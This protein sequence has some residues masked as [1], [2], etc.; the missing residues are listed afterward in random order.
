MN[1]NDFGDFYATVSQVAPALLLAIVVDAGLEKNLAG[2]GNIRTRFDLVF[3]RL[4]WI[5]VVLTAFSAM[6]ISLWQLSYGYNDPRM[7]TTVLCALAFTSFALSLLLLRRVLHN[8]PYHWT[9]SRPGEWDWEP[10]HNRWKWSGQGSL[11]DGTT[12]AP[13]SGEVTLNWTSTT[14]PPGK[15]GR[16]KYKRLGH[17]SGTWTWYG[18]SEWKTPDGQSSG[19]YVVNW[20]HP[21]PPPL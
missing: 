20:K 1:G 4:A 14:M 11:F 7:R 9:A 10:L 13:H 17:D 16:W 15:S 3:A 6:G 5:L 18:A 12:G 19:A 21:S 2:Y 8:F